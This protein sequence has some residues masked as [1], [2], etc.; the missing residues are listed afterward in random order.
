MASIPPWGADRDLLVRRNVP[1]LGFDPQQGVPDSEEA[2][3]RVH[4]EDIKR[5]R[6]AL[7]FGGAALEE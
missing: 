5:I 4:R 6:E 7:V 2:W 3:Q 1:D